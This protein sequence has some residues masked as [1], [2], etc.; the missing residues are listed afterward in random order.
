M[1]I[2]FLEKTKRK[3]KMAREKSRVS[4]DQKP[5]EQPDKNDVICPLILLITKKKGDP[6]AINY[7]LTWSPLIKLGE[8]VGVW[9]SAPQL[10]L[11]E[12]GKALVA[13]KGYK[14][15]TEDHIAEASGSTTK[16]ARSHSLAFYKTLE[17]GKEKEIFNWDEDA[18]YFTQ[19]EGVK[20][21][22]EYEGLVLEGE[23]KAQKRSWGGRFEKFTGKSFED[24]Q[25]LYPD[26]YGTKTKVKVTTEPVA[27]EVEPEDVPEDD[28]TPSMSG[29]DNIPEP[30]DE[31]LAAEEEVEIET[32]EEVVAGVTATEEA[33]ILTE[34]PWDGYDQ[35]GTSDVIKK[36]RE[37]EFA[38]PEDLTSILEYEKDLGKGMGHRPLLSKEI[39]R[40][41]EQKFPAEDVPS[42]DVTTVTEEETEEEEEEP[43]DEETFDL[44]S[45][46]DAQTQE[47]DSITW[48]ASN[49]KDEVAYLVFVEALDQEYWMPEG[50]T[51]IENVMVNVVSLKK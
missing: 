5:S 47:V 8:T 2:V 22:I 29:E 19:D 48:R 38:N 18:Y 40:V 4:P 28:D 46:G 16:Q 1:E 11:T 25:Q 20:A 6:R 34:E 49:G 14:A 44:D 3:K 26:L 37:M 27:E 9:R 21:R 12:A 32:E 7:D 36:L 15:L 42:S 51:L 23:A 33:K 41:I 50:P 10:Q 17:E 43:I 31:Q 13:E 30:T 35:E 24:L 45:F 39:E